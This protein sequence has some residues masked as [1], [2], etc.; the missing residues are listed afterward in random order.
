LPPASS[1]TPRTVAFRLGKN[2]TL[3]IALQHLS[4]VGIKQPDGGIDL[5]LVQYTVVTGTPSR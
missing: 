3:G 2:H 1:S 5:V 4:N